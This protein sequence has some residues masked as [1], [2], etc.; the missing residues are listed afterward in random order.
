MLRVFWLKLYEHHRQS[1]PGD[2]NEFERCFSGSVWVFNSVLGSFS[3]LSSS[4]FTRSF[5]NG[6]IAESVSASDIIN[7]RLESA[8]IPKGICCSEVVVPPACTM[9][10]TSMLANVAYVRV[11]VFKCYQLPL[12]FGSNTEV[13]FVQN[14]RPT[15][16]HSG[17]SSTS[18]LREPSKKGR[19]FMCRPFR[20]MHSMHLGSLPS[21]L[22]V[23]KQPLGNSP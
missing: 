9:T 10:T 16:V 8:I 18:C 20:V 11:C 21:L 4:L 3:A 1:A 23:P 5:V 15:R 22:S 2:I 17:F 7:F 13:V 12:S 19:E 14:N 6:R